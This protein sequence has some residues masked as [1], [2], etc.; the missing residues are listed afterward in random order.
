MRVPLCSNQHDVV[1]SDMNAQTE[2]ETIQWRVH[3]RSPPFRVHQFL[4]TPE[5]R[6]RFWAEWAEQTGDT[7][8]FVFSSGQRLRSKVFENISPERFCVSYFGGSRVTFHLQA[9]EDGGTDLLLTESGVAA[10]ER[11]GNLAGWVTVLLTLKAAVDFG[12]DLRSGDP[13]RTWEQGY[14]DV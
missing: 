13:N 8:D 3:F 4:A 1:P 10:D 11:E 12:V 2:G 7:I 6:A 9:A 14:V 5:G